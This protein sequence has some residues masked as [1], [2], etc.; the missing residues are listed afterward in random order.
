MVFYQSNRKTTKKLILFLLFS[1]FPKLDKEF[2]E[3]K[4][5]PNLSTESCASFRYVIQRII[6][7]VSC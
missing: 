5:T 2:L 3:H 7:Y 4:V 1:Y 6:F